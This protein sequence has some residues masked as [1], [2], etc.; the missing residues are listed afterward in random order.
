MS[1]AI[2]A[3]GIIAIVVKA[4]IWF[5]SVAWPPT[6]VGMSGGNVRV[7]LL[8]KTNANWNSFQENTHTSNVVAT[9]PGETNGNAT[10]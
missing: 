3:T 10:L 7:A 8:V 9:N 5:H 4:A 2:A 1:K 6:R